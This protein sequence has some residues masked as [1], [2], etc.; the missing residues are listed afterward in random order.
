VLS[1]RRSGHGEG[2]IWAE[3]AAAFVI[4]FDNLRCVGHDVI[5]DSGIVWKKD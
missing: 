5:N 1:P 2:E 4:E 3:M